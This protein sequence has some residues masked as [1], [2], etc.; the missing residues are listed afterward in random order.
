M[1]APLNFEEYARER[2]RNI[3][4]SEDYDLVCVCMVF[5]I[6]NSKIWHS[7]NILYSAYDVTRSNTTEAQLFFNFV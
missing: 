1:Y 3:P 6:L 2:A 4:H 7:I 5:F